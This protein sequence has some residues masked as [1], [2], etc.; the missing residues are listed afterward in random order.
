MKV[1]PFRE[2]KIAL[3]RRA[4]PL[5]AEGVFELNIIFDRKTPHHLRLYQMGYSHQV[6][7]LSVCFPPCP[8]LLL[9][10]KLSGLVLISISY[11]KL[12]IFIVSPQN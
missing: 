6:E 2:G 7:P 8:N 1:K 10:D 11:S 12:K 3:N 9:S 5:S 4:L